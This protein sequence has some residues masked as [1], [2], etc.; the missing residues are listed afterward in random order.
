MHAISVADATTCG[1]HG[2]QSVEDH[3]LVWPRDFRP[4]ADRILAGGVSH[5]YQYAT[6][7]ARRATQLSANAIV[8]PSGLLLSSA[9]LPVAYATGRDCFALRAG[10]ITNL[11]ATHMFKVNGYRVEPRGFSHGIAPQL[12]AH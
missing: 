4:E 8:P 6:D 1:S 3:L 2:L 12:R 9:K 11:S 5:R 10:S 7:T